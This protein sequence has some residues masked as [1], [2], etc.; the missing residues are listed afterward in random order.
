MLLLLCTVSL[1]CNNKEH[2]SFIH[3]LSN[4]I[5]DVRLEPFCNSIRVEDLSDG[6]QQNKDII[7][8]LPPNTLS[9]RFLGFHFHSFNY[10]VHSSVFI[11]SSARRRTIRLKVEVYF[12]SS[13]FARLKF[14]Q[15]W[16][17]SAVLMSYANAISHRADGYCFLTILTNNAVIPFLLCG[18][19]RVRKI[20]IQDNLLTD[21]LRKTTNQRG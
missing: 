16:I 7:L 8:P 9:F 2:F 1:S 3:T 19:F 21:F 12:L 18:S 20:Q 15:V 10:V 13:A 17:S 4:P 14:L 5:Y 6:N 11:I